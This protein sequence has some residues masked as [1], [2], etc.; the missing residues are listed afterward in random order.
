MRK[1]QVC[2]RERHEPT[3]ENEK[4]AKSTVE[5]TR[6]L[7]HNQKIPEILPQK[8]LSPGKEPLKFPFLLSLHCGSSPGV[9]KLIQSFGPACSQGRGPD[10]ECFISILDRGI[11]MKIQKD[12]SK[13]I[14][15][16]IRKL[17]WPYRGNL[18]ERPCPIIRSNKE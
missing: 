1:H 9:L 5:N 13:A 10:I 2:R 7:L 12:T 11:S 14:R 16:M 15:P 8:I 4:N 3:A 6:I 17:L 18:K